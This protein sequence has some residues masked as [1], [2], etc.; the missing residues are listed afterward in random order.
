MIS[1]L[2]KEFNF[3]NYYSKISSFLLLILLSF[4]TFIFLGAVMGINNEHLSYFEIISTIFGNSLSIFSLLIIFLFNTLILFYFLNNDFI[5]IRMKN[6]KNFLKNIARIVIFQ[7]IIL[8]IWIVI[9]V[10]ISLNIFVKLRYGI[11]FLENRGTYDILYVVVYVLRNLIWILI[12]SLIQI[13]C[14][15]NLSVKLSVLFFLLYFVYLFFFGLYVPSNFIVTNLSDIGVSIAYF[16]LP[17]YYNS[18]FIEIMISLS[19]IFLMLLI[20]KFMYNIKFCFNKMF[21][22][23]SNVFYTLIMI[24]KK[25]KSLFFLY[26][27]MLISFYVFF[28]FFSDIVNIDN[29][30]NIFGL[31]YSNTSSIIQL[32]LILF[33]NFFFFYVISS[34]FIEDIKNSKITLLLRI[35]L[36][37]Y[38]ILKIV[39]FCV[40]LF[41][42][43]VISYFLVYV[44][45]MF[46]SSLLFSDILNLFFGDFSFTLVI[47]FVNLLC[48]LLFYTNSSIKLLL[49]PLIIGEFYCYT[50][51]FINFSVTILIILFILI[52][53]FISYIFKKYYSDIIENIE[54][55]G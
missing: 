24:I 32:L 41:L 33:Y 40:M 3:F 18:F 38:L 50:L 44:L 9:I 11:Y 12:I 36:N 10:I 46:S 26:F 21:L 1:E 14:F 19:Y 6:E 17:L 28:A 13:W 54:N 8:Y 39:L 16:L 42:I 20:L 4:I 22:L 31:N 35:S 7:N 34:N 55:G 27:L 45:F 48:M 47:A 49:V 52:L 15:K 23:F 51:S 53:L 25:K 37:K 29:F 2:K 5:K 30:K 43:K